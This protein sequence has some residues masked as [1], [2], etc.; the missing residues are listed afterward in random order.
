MNLI[1]NIFKKLFIIH[2]VK[3]VKRWFIPILV[4]SM[5]LASSFQGNTDKQ[6]NSRF[7]KN[8][9]LIDGL[10]DD[11]ENNDYLFLEGKKVDSDNQVTIRSTWDY[12]SL[13]VLFEVKDKD[14]QAYQTIQDHPRLFLDD[15]IEVLIDANNNKNSY[16]GPDDIVYHINLY[17]IKKDDRGTLECKSSPLWNGNAHY[18][19]KIFGTVNDKTDIDSGYTVEIGIPWSELKLTPQTGLKIGI[20]F[21]NGDNDG[22]GR[23]LFNWSGVWPMRSP[24][25]FGNLIL[26]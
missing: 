2:H 21:A 1:I 4:A 6:I 10:S 18:Y 14:L 9:I 26:I 13:Y 15:M 8:K 5:F 7:S 11:W 20:N 19:V 24:Y 3:N 12:D 17:G 16:W 22:K 23:Q 25:S